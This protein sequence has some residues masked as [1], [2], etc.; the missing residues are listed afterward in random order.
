[1]PDV[2]AC[3]DPPPATACRV[4]T[5]LSISLRELGIPPR[6]AIMDAVEREAAKDEADFWAL[7]ALISA[8]VALSAGLIK[9]ANSALFGGRHVAVS[10]YDAVRKLG[11]QQVA[12]TIAALSLQ[13]VFA[14]VPQMER[15]WDSSFRTAC[16]AAWL[17]QQLPGAKTV[18]VPDV[19]SYTLFRDAGIPALLVPLGPIYRDVLQQANRNHELPFTEVEHHALDVNHALL[20][21][22]L[23]RTWGL[24]PEMLAAIA[25]HHDAAAIAGQRPGV[26][27]RAR[28][29][30]ALAQLA[31]YLWQCQSGQAMTCEWIKLGPACLDVLALPADDLPLWLERSVEITATAH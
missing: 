3:A 15:F 2:T 4:Q 21:A 14:H 22:E 18:G 27:L 12:R 26:P 20:G 13:R 23:A 6:P 11:L 30:I 17:A 31:E 29:M 7:Q 1:M 8:D 5:T 25:H 9:V 16:L 24:P 28:Q 10:V 19:Y